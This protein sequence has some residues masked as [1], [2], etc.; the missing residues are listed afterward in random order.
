M[1]AIRM[2]LFVFL[3]CL[4]TLACA[5]VNC[6]A[7]RNVDPTNM[8]A[9]HHPVGK[10][11]PQRAEFNQPIR[12]RD[13][14]WFFDLNHN[15]SPDPGEPR[16]FGSLRVIECSSCHADSPDAKTPAAAKVFLRQDVSVLCLVCHNL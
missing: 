15:A 11:L 1:R 10:P 6:G 3:A 4:S 5:E 9:R 13:G 16:L 14:G 12:C 8:G 2:Q 7:E